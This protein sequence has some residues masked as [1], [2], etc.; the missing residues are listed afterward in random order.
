MRW[1]HLAVG[2]VL[3]VLVSVA[4]VGFPYMDSGITAGNGNP[5][6]YVAA[7]PVPNSSLGAQIIDSDDARIKDNDAIQRVIERAAKEDQYVSISV[8]ESQ[9]E[10][11]MASLDQVP[12]YNRSDVSPGVLVNCDGTVVRVYYQ[13]AIPS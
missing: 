4:A 7:Q 6:H 5:N 11:I 9:Y 12:S 13:T 10:A 8:N 3:I 1:L 2:M